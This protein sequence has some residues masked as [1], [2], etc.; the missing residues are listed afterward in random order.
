MA[1]VCR[2]SATGRRLAAPQE[3]WWLLRS[4]EPEGSRA[5]SCNSFFAQRIHQHPFHERIH[6]HLSDSLPARALAAAARPPTALCSISTHSRS[7]TPASSMASTDTTSCA[8]TG[9]VGLRIHVGHVFA[10]VLPAARHPWQQHPARAWDTSD[11][12]L[13]SDN[14]PDKGREVRGPV[15]NV[16]TH[17]FQH[18][19]KAKC[20]IACCL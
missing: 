3:R 13:R 5:C 14:V 19:H 12:A 11:F 16:V 1:S 2:H 8:R 6:A 20:Y 7:C 10:H 18:H 9:H 17:V 4:A 15:G